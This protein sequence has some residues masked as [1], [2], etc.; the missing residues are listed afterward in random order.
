M[1]VCVCSVLVCVC[2]CPFGS[3]V[4]VCFGDLLCD[5][6]R[7]CVFLWLCV[8]GVLNVFVCFVCE[9]LSDVL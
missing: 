4:F 9:L 6:A 5:V 8:L 2:L 1:F 3:S 7:L